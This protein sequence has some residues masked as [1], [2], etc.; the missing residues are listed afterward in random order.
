MKAFRYAVN[1]TKLL[2]SLFLFFCSSLT[3]AAQREKNYI[4]LFDCTGSM[5]KNHL[6][7]PAQ[8]ALDD[9]ITIRSS[10]PG[11]HFFIIPFGDKTYEIFSLNDKDYPKKK[12]EITGA[13]D[14]HIKEAKYTNISD[15]LSSGFKQIDPNKDNE[16]Y[17]FTDGNP[18][19]PDS[20]SKVAETINKWC[21]NHKNT[22]LFYVA[23]TNGIVNPTIKKAIDE[24]KD[25]EI[26]QCENGQIPIIVNVSTDVYTNLEELSQPIEF[27][28]SLPG[29]Y[30]LSSQSSDNLFDFKIEGNKASNG[31]FTA[32]VTPK[33]GQ[34]VEALHQ[35]LEGNDYEFPVAIKS[36]DP[37]FTIANPEI[38]VH[39]SDKIPSRLSLADGQD[40]LIAEDC[41]WYDAFLWSDAAPDK[42]T[43]WD[44]A[45][46]FKNALS[47]SRLSLKFQIPDG[48][49]D[50]FK[51]WYNGRPIG[52]GA[53]IDI[54]P[55]QPAILEV[56]FDHDAQTGKRYFSLIPVGANEITLIN[57]QPAENYTGTSLRTKYHV[58]WN[59]LK[60]I[61]FWL[62]IILIAALVLWFAILKRIFFPT[63]KM[64]KI[65]I[66]GP[67]S[68]YASKKLKGARKVV[69]TSKRKSQNIIS[70]LFTGEIRFL[71]ADHFSPEINITPVGG[72]KK[73]KLTSDAIGDNS[74][75]FIPAS[76]FS[77]YDTGSIQNRATNEKSNIDFS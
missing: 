22:K 42:K 2:L 39:V 72:K 41:N 37:R 12:S 21:A 67:G 14:K 58:G 71:K 48:Q 77:Q 29:N 52:N 25:A 26:V 45:P 70:R 64:G 68:Y 49:T 66:T 17:L 44:L 32:R 34:S 69:L 76:I 7:E 16:I 53:V 13:F 28:F 59:P 15:V 38:T 30:N 27:Y 47:N 18:N 5:I 1:N 24:C 11:T 51:A 65:T 40:E 55:G 36:S 4:Y 19:G 75:D 60:T 62:G 35:R 6:W 31:K 23:L 63:I 20:D 9:D 43:R 73:V 3:V 61:L 56:Q 57:D 10:I 50:D 54:I 74:W 46:V 33:S 8:K